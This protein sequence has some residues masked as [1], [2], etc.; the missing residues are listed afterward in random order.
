[1]LNIGIDSGT[2]IEVLICR[3]FVSILSIFVESKFSQLF[4]GYSL[5]KNSPI[6]FGHENIYEGKLQLANGLVIGDAYFAMAA[7]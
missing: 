6:G 2:G 3:Y 4:I 5:S 7:L 1:M